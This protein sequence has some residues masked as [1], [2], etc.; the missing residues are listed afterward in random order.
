MCVNIVK[1][2]KEFKYDAEKPLEEQINGS[3]EIIVNYLENDESVHH[4]IEEI[5]K[6]SQT[7][8]NSEIKIK[9]IPNNLINGVRAKKKVLN[10]TKSISVNEL[11]KLM[12]T[13]YQENDRKLSEIVNI[14]MGKECNE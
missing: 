12:A 6:Y 8:F 11:I 1:G 4:F 14:C 7:S 9:V 13:S 3:S 10:A 2:N 5:Q